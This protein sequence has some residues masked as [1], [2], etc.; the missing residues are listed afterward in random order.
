MKKLY[1]LTLL[2]VLYLP[3][4]ADVKLPQLFADNMVLQRNA[5]I[6]IWG[7]AE[8]GEKITIHLHQQ[9]KSVRADKE[10]N[11]QV[12]LDWEQA[13]GPYELSVNGKN[14]IVLKG[15]LVGEVWICSGQSNMEFALK[16]ALNA[17]EEIKAACYPQIRSFTVP[18]NT[19]FTP[20]K[21]VKASSWQVCTPET[22]GNFSAVAYFFA[23]RLQ[24]TLKVPIGLIHTSWG[25]TNMETWTSREALLTRQDFEDLKTVGP[26]S[27]VVIRKLRIEKTLDKIRTFQQGNISADDAFKWKETDYDDH[28]WVRIKVPGFWESQGL[29]DF[30][31]VVWYRKEVNLTA[32]QV[33]KGILLELGMVDDQDETYVN[34]E[35]VGATYY[36]QAPRKYKIPAGLLKEG[37]N[38]IAVRVMDTGAGGGIYGDDDSIRLVVDGKSI[39][40]LAGEWRTRVDTGAIRHGYEGPNSYPS[41]LFNAMISP[42]IPY[43]IRGAIWYQGESN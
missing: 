28:T 33:Q 1:F 7:W 10:G 14:Q 37:R 26:S 34:G 22:A 8:A 38:I 4:L 25:G 20:C 36:H 27:L 16:N 30:D 24:E 3:A 12:K 2:G 15:V 32:E 18:K 40:P 29:P 11:W 35:K 42:L 39:L 13:G 31:G 9:R 5:P 17:A 41:L 6:T 23:R 21:D 19:S 43:T